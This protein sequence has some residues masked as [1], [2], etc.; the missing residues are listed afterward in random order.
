[1]F[2]VETAIETAT[3]LDQHPRVRERVVA[4]YL[5]HGADKAKGMLVTILLTAG[6]L[7]DARDIYRLRRRELRRL[8][9]IRADR[10]GYRR[11]VEAHRLAWSEVGWAKPR[12]PVAAGKRGKSGGRTDRTERKVVVK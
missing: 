1:M 3:W 5:A 2:A 10:Q 12:P 11:A 4:T 7:R 8:L 6:V 9:G